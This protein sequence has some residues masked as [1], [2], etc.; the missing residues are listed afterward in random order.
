[1]NAAFTPW[2]MGAG[3]RRYD[4]R[5]PSKACF[6]VRNKSTHPYTKHM[7]AAL[8]PA[9]CKDDGNQPRHHPHTRRRVGAVLSLDNLGDR[10]ATMDDP[11]SWVGYCAGVRMGNG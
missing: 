2:L 6:H 11:R 3:D 1:M 9:S 7:P 8:E 5:I 4:V 10:C